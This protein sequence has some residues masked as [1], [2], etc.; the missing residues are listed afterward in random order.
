MSSQNVLIALTSY[1]DVFY[2]DGAKTGVF[3]VEALHPFNEYKAK[4]YNVQ[5][6]SET[7][8]FGWDDHSLTE[9]FLVGQDKKDFDNESSDFQHAL[10]KVKKASDINADDYKIFFAAAGHGSCFDFPTA[11]GLQDLAL[12][13]YANGG[14]VAAVCHGPAIF[15]GLNDKKTGENIAKGKSLT[16][17]TDE[18]E[19]IMNVDKI[20]KQKGVK[21]VCEIFKECGIKYMAPIGPWDNFSI[22]DGKIVTG[23]NP[24][25]AGSTAKRS[26]IA[27]D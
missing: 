5:F 26:I 19:A 15:A 9:T 12:K 2:E 13:I 20:M 8:K 6:V 4:G 18:G 17:F 14:V 1:N 16:G 24:A 27:L 7:G 25:S 11:S 21:T 3:L 10:K 22:T 23:V